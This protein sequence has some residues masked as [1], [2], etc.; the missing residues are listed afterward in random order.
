MQDFRRGRLPK[1][2]L[3]AWALALLAGV[4]LSACSTLE[5][6][7]MSDFK[8]GRAVAGLPLDDPGAWKS[9]VATANRSI[10]KG[11]EVIWLDYNEL[12][13]ANLAGGDIRALHLFA[14]ADGTDARPVLAVA[15]T[16]R[17]ASYGSTADPNEW[18]RRAEE[19][20]FAPRELVGFS[21]IGALYLTD[22]GEFYVVQAAESRRSPPAACG[23]TYILRFTGNGEEL[24]RFLDR[25]A[26]T[27]PDKMAERVGKA[28]REG[29]RSGIDGALRWLGRVSAVCDPA[30]E[31]AAAQARAAIV[32]WAE[33]RLAV[34]DFE[35]VMA[36]PL[37][38]LSRWPGVPEMKA[39]LDAM[40]LTEIRT[41]A[42]LPIM[43][44][45]RRLRGKLSPRAQEQF[46]RLKL[47]EAKA[48]LACL[49]VDPDEPPIAQELPPPPPAA[50]LGSLD[51]FLAD[52][53][54]TLE[55]L[56]VA[57]WEKAWNEQDDLGKLAILY[58]LLR[59]RK[60]PPFPAAAAPML[61]RFVGWLWQLGKE[62]D[63]QQMV[64]DCHSPSV[65]GNYVPR[66]AIKEIDG[67]AERAD[68]GKDYLAPAAAGYWYNLYT[69]LDRFVPALVD[70]RQAGEPELDRRFR[71]S[72]LDGMFTMIADLDSVL[73]CHNIHQA[74]P[75]AA[76]CK[77]LSKGTFAALSGLLYAWKNYS[78]I[79]KEL[80]RRETAAGV[81]L[82]EQWRK[83]PI[84]EQVEN[85]R[86]YLK[87]GRQVI[88]GDDF[89]KYFHWLLDEVGK[90]AAEAQARNRPAA[91]MAWWLT[92]T[93]LIRPE[94][95]NSK[96]NGDYKKRPYG[97]EREA[98]WKGR[99]PY[100]RMGFEASTELAIAV[101]EQLVVRYGVVPESVSVGDHTNKLIEPYC[102]M[103]LPGL[104]D[105]PDW[106]MPWVSPAEKTV[107]AAVTSAGR[108]LMQFKFGPVRV[109]ELKNNYEDT[110]LTEYRQTESMEVRDQEAY[111]KAQKKVD[112]LKKQQLSEADT[113]YER[114][115]GNGGWSETRLYKPDEKNLS[116]GTWKKGGQWEGVWTKETVVD[117]ELARLRDEKAGELAK[118]QAE[119]AKAGEKEQKVRIEE[120][121]AG[122]KM[123]VISGDVE[124]SHVFSLGDLVYDKPVRLEGE[125]ARMEK[126]ARFDWHLS[127]DEFTRWLGRGSFGL[128]QA[129]DAAR[130]YFVEQQLAK[131]LPVEAQQ[132]G[133]TEQELAEEETFRRYL[134]LNDWNRK[135][136]PPWWGLRVP[137]GNVCWDCEDLTRD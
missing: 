137:K 86:K 2:L 133:W 117:P 111:D 6:A 107:G 40:V 31:E 58:K 70:S 112:E 42:A 84:E 34:A 110:T 48:L 72:D 68:P 92:Y 29:G 108:P 60:Q 51:A 83:L 71:S 50:P 132:N 100:A 136:P 65:L 106:E 59:G 27:L 17:L 129:Y 79:V 113:T 81:A 57:A 114:W 30:A 124:V 74:D 75:E 78:P 125:I 134:L 85:L 89:R 10:K 73:S 127:K 9:M 46:E 53:P 103:L 135:G 63:L 13:V 55:G 3:A 90:R 47:P 49:P 104:C 62:K 128:P 23:L 39:R 8:S 11:A 37:S 77:P 1:S 96:W 22:R 4:Q 69:Y 15:V 38:D 64:A 109:G 25:I 19:L 44:Q 122:A 12:H 116:G 21:T 119:L 87:E 97:G 82:Q 66:D 35:S 102:R 54:T 67:M 99:R 56:N 24:G 105:D 95:S 43:E 115:A 94:G 98:L 14:D 26:V 28:L 5:P 61:G 118:A 20:G 88:R 131:D 41:L 126:T 7:Q 93:A 130:R 101:G 121:G 36:E 18:R 80:T 52:A 33:K 123:Q 76:G 32:E 45:R 16:P 91:A 120:Y